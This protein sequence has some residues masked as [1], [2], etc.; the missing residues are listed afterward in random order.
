VRPAFAAAPLRRAASA[1]ITSGGWRGVYCR[2]SA[3]ANQPSLLM[4]LL[5]EDLA[6]FQFLFARRA[7]GGPPC[8]H[9]NEHITRNRDGVAV[10]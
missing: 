3:E 2:L 10:H 1:V 4:M 8:R 6:G 7:R 9:N 5:A